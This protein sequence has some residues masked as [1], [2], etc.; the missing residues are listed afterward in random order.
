MSQPPAIVIL[1]AL[2]LGDFLTG[3][4]AYRALR[5]AYPDHAVIL[6]APP[7]LQALAALTGAIDGV[8][9]TGELQP[10]RW[11][12]PPP[13]IAV[14]LHG[15]GPASHDLVRSLGAAITIMYASAAEP[16]V[17]G[18]WWP[19]AEHEVL[20]W[21]RLLE[22]WGLRAD[23]DALMLDRPAVRPLAPGA[24]LL[25]PGAASGSR[26]WPAA[27]FAA[28]AKALTAAGEQ[29]VISGSAAERPLARRVAQL[30][31]LPSGS[32]IAGQTDISGLA[33]TVAAARMVISND[34]GVAHLAVAYG[35]PSVTLFGPVSPAL[36]GPPAGSKRHL[37][38]WRGSG[39]RPGD[40]HG[41]RAD[42][43]LLRIGVADVLA[44]VD[45][46]RQRGAAGRGATQVIRHPAADGP[47]PG[48]PI[49]RRATAPGQEHSWRRAHCAGTQP[50]PGFRDRRR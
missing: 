30:A 27:R 26:R 33:A 25:H 32:V 6:A 21:C 50:F 10:I 1:R 12:G 20:R 29:V 11:H 46:L 43:R 22:W 38:L 15:N 3:V 7:G 45:R 4:P 41:Q 28:V 31:G 13:D 14:D 5:A 44:A 35:V 8:L 37:A 49:P 42:P 17:T 39:S 18:P 34:T 24:V 47:G 40:P 48:S 36:W 16:D 9:P 23:P 2:G 19:E